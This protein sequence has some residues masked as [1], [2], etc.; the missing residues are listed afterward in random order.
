MYWEK[1]LDGWIKLNFDGFCRWNLGPS[2]GGG[3]IQDSY[4]NFIA[5]FSKKKKVFGTN[6]GAELQALICG[7]PMGK[8]MAIKIFVLNL[9]LN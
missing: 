7:V 8:H 1:L 9:N 2:G 5:A 3:I 6:N 4:G